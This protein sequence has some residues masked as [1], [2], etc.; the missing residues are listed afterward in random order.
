MLDAKD[1]PP[2]TPIY[3]YVAGDDEHTNVHIDSEKL[4]VWC[5][6]H[7]A[8]LE[9]VWI[10]VEV[11]Q[12]REW[13]RDNVVDVSHVMRVME[14]KSLDPVILCRIDPPRP[15]WPQALYVDGHHR[16]VA[17]AVLKVKMIPA[18]ILKPEQWQQFQIAGL[19]D[20]TQE[21]LRAMPT[22]PRR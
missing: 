6:E 7:K 18:F 17:A 20:M 11:K 10:P 12:A 14:M 15:K 3:S 16:Y 2:G 13:I 22:K 9:W 19:P 1:Y 4:R 5:V 21:L 8:E